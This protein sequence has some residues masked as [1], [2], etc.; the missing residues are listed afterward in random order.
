MRNILESHFYANFPDIEIREVEDY[1]KKM[2]FDPAKN[3]MWASDYVFT[4]PNPYPLR[5]YVDYGLDK[6][7]KPEHA[8]D[9]LI[10][11]S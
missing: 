3:N 1:A 5:T 10:S 4:R 11:T 6:D 8:I 7:P 9:P 2:V